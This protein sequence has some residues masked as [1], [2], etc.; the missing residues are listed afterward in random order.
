MTQTIEADD[1]IVS[2][3]DTLDATRRARDDLAMEC[4]QARYKLR[5]DRDKINAETFAR[6]RTLVNMHLLSKIRE[7]RLPPID[8]HRLLRRADALLTYAKSPFNDRGLCGYGDYLAELRSEARD[9]AIACFQLAQ[10]V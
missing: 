8:Q 6:L 4:L 9:E 5:L 1:P 2:P 3:Y 7:H 10:V